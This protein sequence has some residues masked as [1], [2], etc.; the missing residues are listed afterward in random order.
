[1]DAMKKICLD[2]MKI[3]TQK[4]APPMSTTKPQ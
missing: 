4:A 3:K 2:Q 1:M